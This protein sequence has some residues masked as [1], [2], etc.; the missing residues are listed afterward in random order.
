MLITLLNGNRV[1]H[2]YCLSK[3]TQFS[4]SDLLH[5]KGVK[6]VRWKEESVFTRLTNEILLATIVPYHNMRYL[7]AAVSWAL[8][9]CNLCIPI[10]E[11]LNWDNF[12]SKLEINNFI[13]IFIFNFK[14][15]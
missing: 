8:G 12:F 4:R 5:D 9:G 1:I 3:G 10:Y 11:P 2:P 6:E 15:I 14:F 7:E 13:Y